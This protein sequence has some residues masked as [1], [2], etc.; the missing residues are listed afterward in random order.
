ML[1]KGRDDAQ[2]RGCDSYE[3]FGDEINVDV[4]RCA[5]GWELEKRLRAVVSGKNVTAN[6]AKNAF[7][8]EESAE[9]NKSR[10]CSPHR[11]GESGLGEV[12]GHVRIRL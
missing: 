9:V 11:D 4:D 12:G 3:G 8:Y 2:N 6:G 7:A 5:H 10:E 1:L